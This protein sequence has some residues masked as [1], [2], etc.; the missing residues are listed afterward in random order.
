[1]GLFSAGRSL[2][3]GLL[4]GGVFS[5]MG[6][7]EIKEAI[8]NPEPTNA[9]CQQL[10][11][12]PVGKEWLTV[13]GCVMDLRR[14]TY[15]FKEDKPSEVTDLY[16]P[17]FVDDENGPERAKLSLHTTDRE[18]IKRYSLLKALGDRGEDL[19]VYFQQH[20]SD[21]IVRET[22]SGM[23]ETGMNKSSERHN[24]I[25]EIDTDLAPDFVVL[26]HNKKPNL[27]GGITMLGLGAIFCL[28]GVFRGIRSVRR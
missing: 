19:Q 27:G 17:V 14:A 23:I 22:L 12:G 16:I 5:V 26:R 25:K 3:G 18:L 15:F 10:H 7:Q 21:F 20:A 28:V 24:K 9:T 6:G 1:M 8:G 13:S 11:A 4:V 2:F